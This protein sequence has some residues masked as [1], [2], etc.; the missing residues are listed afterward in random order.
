MKKTNPTPFETKSFAALD[1]AYELISALAPLVTAVARR[2]RALASQL[3][4]A[5]SSIPLNLA[6]GWALEAGNKKTRYLSALGS[7][8]EVAAVL[9]VARRWGYISGAK[10]SS[11]LELLDRV[12]AMTYRLIHPR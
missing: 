4:R 3:R 12:S 1:R 9:E 6:E 11:A 10:A 2:D 5:A 8:R 7:A